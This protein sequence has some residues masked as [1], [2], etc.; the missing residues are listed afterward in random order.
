MENSSNIIELRV[1]ARLRKLRAARRLTLETL[2]ASAGV[3]KSMISLIE[4]GE[5]SPTAGVLDRLA[6]SLGVTLAAMFAEPDR[7]DADPVARHADQPRWS[8]PATGY[9]R[10][11]LSPPGF[12][13]PLE[14]VEVEMP[15]GVR[16][17]YDSFGRSQAV[18]QQI[19]VVSGILEMT[20]G[21]QLYLLQQGDCLA[22][23]LD[24]PT[25]FR[26]PT[27]RESRYIVAL[28]VVPSAGA[29]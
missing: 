20:V 9:I 4:R 18:H 23:R 2:A 29:A 3:S 15:P 19:W 17:A 10:R 12:A 13:S 27:E 22:M 1:A 8:D 6:A 26:N 16:V 25:A 5:C 28:T 7:D 24:R 21:D 14:L 11:N